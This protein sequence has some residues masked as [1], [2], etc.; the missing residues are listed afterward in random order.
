MRWSRRLRGRMGDG[1]GGKCGAKRHTVETKK[2]L[3]GRA[4]LAELTEKRK[5]TKN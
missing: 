4:D 1:L 2:G 3:G 5:A